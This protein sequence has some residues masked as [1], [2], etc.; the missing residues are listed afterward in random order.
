MSKTREKCQQS[1]V[2]SKR[3]TLAC[4]VS[5][6]GPGSLL[7]TEIPQ[8]KWAKERINGLENNV[9]KCLILVDFYWYCTN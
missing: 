9:C 4:K 7:G 5:Y 2:L 1:C 8:L 3:I 6:P